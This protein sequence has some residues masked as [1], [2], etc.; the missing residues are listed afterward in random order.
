MKRIVFTVTNDLIYDQRMIRICNSLTS[1]GY[2]I[3]LVGRKISDSLPLPHQ[4]FDQKRLSCL[5][6]SGKVFYVEYNLRLFFFLLF[7]KTDIIGAIDLDT[8]FPCY[9]ISKLKGKK[10]VYDA[11]ELFCEMKEIVSRPFIYKCW[12]WLERL[13]VPK[14]KSGYTVNQPIADEFEKMY[15]VKYEVIRN[16]PIYQNTDIPVKKEKFLLYQGA[17]NEGRSFETLI[18]AMQWVDAQLIIC[19]DGNFMRQARDLAKE[20]QVEGKIVF[21][22]KILPEELK[23]VTLQAW[24]GVTLFDAEGKSNYYSLANRFFDYIQ[25]GIP[26]LCV[27]YPVYREINNIYNIAVL[28]DDLSPEG[29][30]QKLNGLLD[31]E[32]LYNTLQQNC[33]E[34][35]KILC[36]QVE[37][38]KLL[39]FYQ[40][41]FN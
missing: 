8:I 7:H 25:A 9:I 29:L 23:E 15:G 37:E 35:R 5:F 39:A 36:W 16:A 1:A 34:A 13:T 3:T 40:K 19:G 28:T 30:S 10:R 24:A 38:K 6:S 41:I 22:G 27:D 14:F 32:Q 21:M 17:V 33:V 31:N 20:Y 2:K 12:K 4:N 26:Q 11:H 18:P